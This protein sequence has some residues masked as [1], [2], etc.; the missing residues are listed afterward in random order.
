MERFL[1]V[2]FPFKRATVSRK[3]ATI[4]VIIIISTCFYSFSLIS[5]NLK[6]FENEMQ[7]VTLGEWFELA[8]V[9]VMFDVALTMIVPFILISIFNFLIVF[10][11]N[12]Q[13]NQPFEYSANKRTRTLSIFSNEQKKANWKMERL[14][15]THKRF[16]ILS[17]HFSELIC[18]NK[19]ITK[20][21]PFAIKSYSTNHIIRLKASSINSLCSNYDTIK[22]IRTVKQSKLS[23]LTKSKSKIK[24]KK[25]TCILLFISTCFLCLN[26]PITICKIFFFIYPNESRFEIKSMNQQN[27]TAQY[28]QIAI[29]AIGNNLS[30]KIV[31]RLSC[32]IYYLNFSVNFF[33]YNLNLLKT[34]K[35]LLGLLA[36]LRQFLRNQFK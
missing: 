17:N 10:R 21:S 34:K 22:T 30:E 14:Q 33:L 29:Q 8:H 31:E 3:K 6:P 23:E 2:Y 24:F 16:S 26:M 27:K 25:T 15:I 4:S 9:F 20:N 36:S 19:S 28:I 13:S 5:S 32:Y 12:N 35:T 7:C 11:L 18:L 1:V